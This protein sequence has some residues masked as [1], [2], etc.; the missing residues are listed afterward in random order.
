MR[1]IEKIRA[2]LRVNPDAI[3]HVWPTYASDA[4]VTNRDELLWGWNL[5]ANGGE[6]ILKLGRYPIH[7]PARPGEFALE[8]APRSSLILIPGASGPPKMKHWGLTKLGGDV[9]AVSPSI[10]LP[11]A[12]H[13]YVTLCAVPNPPP[14]EI[15]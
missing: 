4:F 1:D 15:K 5:N 14:W 8:E 10:H 6:I 9:W 3:L 11:S 2:Q 13:G 7:F 12:F